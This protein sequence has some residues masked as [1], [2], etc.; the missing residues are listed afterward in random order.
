MPLKIIK[1]TPKDYK[2]LSDLC[3]E[4]YPQSYSEWWHDEGKWYIETMY[5][6][7][8]ML[9][10]LKDKNTEFYFLKIDEVPYGY[11]KLNHTFKN[12]SHSFEIERIYLDQTFVGQG[13]GNY[14]LNF[15]IDR[16][17]SLKR[18]KLYLKVMA[19]GKGLIKFYEKNGFET[20]GSELL[21]FELLKTELRTINTMKKIL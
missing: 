16:A 4:I 6:P 20:I 9:L 8:Q 15:G 11:I 10:E 17:K 21:T 14:L 18:K 1:A 2:I 7:N 19:S 13:L 3:F 5:N 12:E